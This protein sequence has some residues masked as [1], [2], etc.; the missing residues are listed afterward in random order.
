[1][2]GGLELMPELGIA[3]GVWSMVHD[4]LAR[5][6]SAVWRPPRSSPRYRRPRKAYRSVLSGLFSWYPP[7][8]TRLTR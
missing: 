5:A 6:Q 2:P 8:S 4:R 3:L 1:M 7:L